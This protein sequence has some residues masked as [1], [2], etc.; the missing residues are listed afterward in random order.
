MRETESLLAHEMVLVLV[1][2]LIGIP[3]H[4]IHSC[5]LCSILNAY[6]FSQSRL[7]FL[8]NP[9]LFMYFNYLGS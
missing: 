4:H 3:H 6:P 5:L 8:W 7:F 1:Y 9:R 2:V